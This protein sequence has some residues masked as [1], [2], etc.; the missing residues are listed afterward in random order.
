MNRKH[1]LL[2]LCVLLMTGLMSGTAVADT[3]PSRAIKLIIPFPPGGE[4]R[5]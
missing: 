1:R 2:S 4:P 5:I 3:Y